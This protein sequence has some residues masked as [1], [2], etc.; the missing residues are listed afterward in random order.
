MRVI[1][2]LILVLF[3]SVG[4][5]NDA[6]L[7]TAGTESLIEEDPVKYEVTIEIKY[8][9][10]SSAKVVEL[11]REFT[12]EHGEACEVDVRVRKYRGNM[13]GSITFYDGSSG[14]ELIPNPTFLWE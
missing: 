13:T 8:N 11:V 4:Y 3:V 12:G 9:A 2:V 14:T 7:T 5:A 6:F 1:L 10:V